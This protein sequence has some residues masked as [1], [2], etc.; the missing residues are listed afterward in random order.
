MSAI[1]AHIFGQKDG[2]T[3]FEGLVDANSEA[4]FDEQLISLKV[5]WEELED[6][7]TKRSENK[8]TFHTWFMKY[9]AEEIKSTMIQSIRIAAG[10]GDPPSEFCTNDSEVINSALKQFLAFKKSDWP[11]FN[12][13]MRKFVLM[14]QE[15]VSKAIISLGQYTLR[16]EYQHFSITP[17][18]WFT[19]LSDEQRKNAQMKLKQALLDDKQ[20]KCS[21]DVG[22]T[23]VDQVDD[24]DARNEHHH[25]SIGNSL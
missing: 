8:L 14:Q 10:L 16:D 12:E 18:R 23:S 17:S 4:E 9:H 2:P 7:R 21:F 24:V 25:P 20:K 1:T 13:K 15:E 3:F 11:I 19:A 5:K 6:Q 22:N